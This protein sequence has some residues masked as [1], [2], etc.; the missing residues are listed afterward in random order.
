MAEVSGG[1]YYQKEDIGNL[2]RDLNVSQKEEVRQREIR[3]WNSPLLLVIFVL[4]LSIE[5]AVRK[6]SQLL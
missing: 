4:C 2:S 5:W 1:K 6:R 3:L